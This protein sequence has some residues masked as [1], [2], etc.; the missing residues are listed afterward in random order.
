MPEFL[1]SGATLDIARRVADIG[2]RNHRPTQ[3][4]LAGQCTG[5]VDYAPF[6]AHEAVHGW[7]ALADP[8]TPLPSQRWV[9]AQHA[10]D[11]VTTT[12]DLRLAL[13]LAEAGL[14]QVVLPLFAGRDVN[15]VQSGAPILELSHEEWLVAHHDARHDPPIR[16]A[17]E[18]VRAF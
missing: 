14:G 17:L 5:R 13:D 2:I 11:I 12:S 8:Q 4:W 15:L 6:A 10:A 1:P 7:I 3:N 9:H 16:A 18:A